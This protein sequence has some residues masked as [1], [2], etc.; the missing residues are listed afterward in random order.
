MVRSSVYPWLM[1]TIGTLSVAAQ[2]S[3]KD[4]RR[5]GPR[6][7]CRRLLGE[8]ERSET[9]QVRRDGDQRIAVALVVGPEHA[10][11]EAFPVRA[12]KPQ[13]PCPG[14]WSAH[15]LHLATCRSTVWR[16][17]GSVASSATAAANS[18][19]SA[20]VGCF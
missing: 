3:T 15:S 7:A 11:A 13:L 17:R 18:A 2:L 6:A 16:S 20:H 9:L 14:G 12:H 8:A 4:S 10:A 1:A 5:R 19:M